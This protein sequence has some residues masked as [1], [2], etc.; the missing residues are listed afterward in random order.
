MMRHLTLA[1]AAL[2][3]SACALAQQTAVTGA[4]A[5]AQAV[6]A[7]I[8]AA[9][10][11]AGPISLIPVVATT[12]AYLGDA[13]GA[14]ALVSADLP[15]LYTFLGNFQATVAAVKAGKPVGK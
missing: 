4:A 8:Q 7:S 1:G 12:E 13:C 10:T 5:E 9:E 3:L 6:C 11:A 14:A 15:F 2:A